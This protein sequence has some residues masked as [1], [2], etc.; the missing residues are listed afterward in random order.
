MTEMNRLGRL[1]DGNLGSLGFLPIEVCNKIYAY[2]L[3]EFH[4]PAYQVE[5]T[6]A[7]L[8]EH[9]E[10]FHFVPHAV[11]TTILR[12]SR[13]VHREAYDLMVKEC[14]FVH[15]K[16]RKIP[17]FL[18]TTGAVPFVTMNTEHV[19]QFKGY[20]LE[21][22]ATYHG[23]QLPQQF[24]GNR[25]FEAMMLAVHL[26][27]LGESLMIGNTMPGFSNHLTL[28]L[29][30]GPM[31]NVGHE[32]RDYEDLESLERYFT[33]K[34]QKKLLRPL[35]DSLYGFQD[36]QICGL[37]LTDVVSSTLT[38]MASS[39]W[40]GPKHVL[41]HLAARKEFGM[42]LFRENKHQLASNSW[43]RDIIEI[44]MLRKGSE[45]SGLV[46]HGGEPFIDRVAEIY[47]QISLNG[48]HIKLKARRNEVLLNSLEA[49]LLHASKAMTTGFWKAGF[50]WRPPEKLE[51]KLHF[52]TACF[53]RL[54]GDLSDAQRAMNEIGQALRLR[55]DDPAILRE[56]QLV[57]QWVLEAVLT[58]P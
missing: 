12:T 23:E 21:V 54:R 9:L 25:T 1:R 29:N 42:Q 37:V 50:T 22:N 48:A 32:A 58:A 27:G 2:L 20:V 55:P 38:A 17:L 3:A 40:A 41:D 6:D 10:D 51:V 47:F 49:F 39:K 16:C 44:D 18:M 4:Q 45:W 57:S 24:G 31:V 15:L 36:V 33:E 14:R 56:R 43:T 34:T 5:L 8:Q 52:R 53:Y 26:K 28:R 11:D 35:A 19:R 46:H 7:E 30:L 13:D